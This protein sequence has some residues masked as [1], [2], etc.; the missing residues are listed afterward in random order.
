MHGS[1]RLLWV[2]VFIVGLL[3]G[4]AVGPGAGVHGQAKITCPDAIGPCPNQMYP[5][6]VPP[7]PKTQVH[8]R[9]SYWATADIRNAHRLLSAAD[10]AGRGLD[11]NT[12]LHDFPYRSRTLAMVIRHVS[13][14]GGNVAQ[15]QMGVGQFF[16]IMGGS[17]TIVAGGQ[18]ADPVTL[19]DKG[20]PVWGELRGSSI[21]GGERFDVKEGDY[22]T[23]PP[24]VPAQVKATTGEGLT[25]MALQVNA[26]MYPWELVR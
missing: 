22:L 3:A 25:Y 12:T 17:G 1:I 16:V 2:P 5:V 14:K 4:S 8:T 21:T 11:P 13:E 6:Q 15:Q 24:N 7:F 9:A 18:I 19:A 10:A 20:P 23:I 26:Q